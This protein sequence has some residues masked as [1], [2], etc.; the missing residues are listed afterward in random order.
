MVVI[1]NFGL[2][3]KQIKELTARDVLGGGKNPKPETEP[4]TELNPQVLYKLEL[5]THQWINNLL[6]GSGKSCLHC[7]V[8]MGTAKAYNQYKVQGII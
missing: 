8:S 2:D 7:G 1:K 3:K 5:C 4:L 6:Y